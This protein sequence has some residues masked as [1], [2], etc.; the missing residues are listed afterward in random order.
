VLVIVFFS[1]GSFSSAFAECK[2]R[3][4]RVDLRHVRDGSAYTST[5]FSLSA[6]LLRQL[7]LRFQPVIEVVSPDPA[8]FKVNL[9]GS[10]SNLLITR[11]LHR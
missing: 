7:F 1:I 2:S 5:G 11:V 3:A 8:P 4:S 6:Q 9:E 10:S